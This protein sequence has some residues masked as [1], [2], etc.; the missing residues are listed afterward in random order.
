MNGCG[1]T[2]KL[3]KELTDFLC[4]KNGDLQL[5]SLELQFNK[6]TAKGVGD[7]F[8]KASAFFRSLTHLELRGNKVTDILPPSSYKSFRNL[9]SLG[10]S[11]NP[12]GA[13]SIQSLETAIQTGVVPNLNTLSLLYTLT[14]DA[15]INGALLATFLPSIASCCPLLSELYLA[16]NFGVSGANAIAEATLLLSNRERIELHLLFDNEDALAFSNFLSLTAR[17][18]SPL[19]KYSCYLHLEDS[20][21]GYDGLLAIFRMLKSENCPIRKLNLNNVLADGISV[22]TLQLLSGQYTT[23]IVSLPLFNVNF[24]LTSLLIDNNNFSG[25]KSHVLTDCIS[26]CQTLEYLSSSNCS[27]SCIE[28]ITLLYHLVSANRRFDSLKQWT[29]TK[30]FIG[31][32]GVTV[33][34]ECQPKLFPNLEIVAKCDLADNQFEIDTTEKMVG[35]CG[36]SPVINLL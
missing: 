5:E 12:L 20:K 18:Y 19:D 26:T 25:K 9:T 4:I 34:K 6:L 21:L 16:D 30:N 31:Q 2:D 13:S 27:L 11:Y 33:L 22:T 3:L 28:I 10:L 23:T 32:K 35:E 1:L 36:R 14:D 17:K 29:L 15:D 24:C 7:L 8:S